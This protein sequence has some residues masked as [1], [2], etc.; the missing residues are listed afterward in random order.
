[1]SQFSDMR[2]A[3]QDWLTAHPEGRLIVL[4]CGL[5][6]TAVRVDLDMP[7]GSNLAVLFVDEHERAHSA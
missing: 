4:E 2:P 3:E 6:Q 1:M 7:S 5:C